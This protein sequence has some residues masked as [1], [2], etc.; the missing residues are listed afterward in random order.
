[1]FSPNGNILISCDVIFDEHAFSFAQL[2]SQKKVTSFFSSSST[3]LPCQT[4][5]PLMVL[6][7][8]T[9]SPTNPP[10]SPTTFNH[11]VASHLPS[12]SAFLLS[13]HP[14]ITRSKNG[15]FKPKAYL[16]S[17]IPTSVPKAL[18]LSH[19]K[20]AMTNE[21]IALLRN[22]TWN[23]VSPPTYRK[24]IGCKWVFKVKENLD[25]TIK[26]YKAC[27][28][29]KG[30]HQIIGFDFLKPTTI[31]IVL[32][33]A[34]NL[35]WKIWQLDVNNALLNGDLHEEIFMIQPEGYID[36]LNPNYVCKL[37]KSLY[38]LKQAPR[39]WFEK[40]HQTLGTLGF[41]S[42]KSNQSLFIN[43]TPT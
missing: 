9:S 42:T 21:Y 1:M 18:Q 43:I 14:M 23:L 17:T 24:L 15:I 11:N 27:L 29:A 26:K 2:Q 13:T 32:T 22:N 41:S 10:I 28:I 12:F 31:H 35:Q 19:W 25:G 20:Q 30:F 16:I 36:P 5:F 39:A 4:S 37:N 40:L 38:G 34:L 8:S 6:I 7:S 33:I 3:S